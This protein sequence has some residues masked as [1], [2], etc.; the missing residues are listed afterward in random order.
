MALIV[1]ATPGSVVSM[2]FRFISFCFRY[3]QA[4]MGVGPVPL[5][6]AQDGREHRQTFGEVFGVCAHFGG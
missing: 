3:G 1:P 6:S 4:E 2:Q 5:G